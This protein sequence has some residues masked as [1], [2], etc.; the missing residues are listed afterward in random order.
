MRSPFFWRSVTSIVLGLANF[1]IA[2]QMARITGRAAGH[3]AFPWRILLRASSILYV[4][5]SA[6]ALIL[7][8]Q[9]IYTMEFSDLADSSWRRNQGW[10]KLHL[11]MSPA[12]AIAIMGRPDQE[13]TLGSKDELQFEYGLHPYDRIGEGFLKFKANP[14]LT[15]GD[16][17]L[18]QKSPEFVNEQQ[19]LRHWLPDYARPCVIYETMETAAVVAFFAMLGLSLISIFP[20]GV[21]RG[22]LSWA[23]YTPLI[24]LLLVSLYEKFH[25]P[26]WRLD[27]LVFYPAYFLIMT[28]WCIRVYAVAHKRSEE[29]KLL[30]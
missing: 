15:S 9:F 3:R 24:A 17:Q 27:S 26:G 22:W 20:W 30:R 21:R 8:V 5:V 10:E 7:L 29:A 12:E 25:L 14:A 28:A 16:L 4:A 19:A 18:A 13:T 1:A 2:V 23:L 11:G 6:M